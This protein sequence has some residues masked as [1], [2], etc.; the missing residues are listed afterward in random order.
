MKFLQSLTLLFSLFLLEQAQA[1]LTNGLV[2]YYPFDGNANDAVG[3]I[4]GTVSD[5]TLTTDRFGNDSSAYQFTTSGNK[6][7]IDLGNSFNGITSGNNKQFSISIWFK[8]S[9]LNKGMQF[10]MKHGTNWCGQIKHHLIITSS[11]RV[12]RESIDDHDD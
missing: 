4:D 12:S 11:P 2:A 9:T 1:Q 7:V 3:N 5:A 10:F 8:R 6:S